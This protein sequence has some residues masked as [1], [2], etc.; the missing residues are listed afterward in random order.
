[1]TFNAALSCTCWNNFSTCTIGST[2]AGAISTSYASYSRRTWTDMAD[3]TESF[4]IGDNV[5]MYTFYWGP[6]YAPPH[7]LFTGSFRYVDEINYDIVT[8][9]C[10]CVSSVNGGITSLPI[11]LTSI[12]YTYPE[13]Y[14][15]CEVTVGAEVYMTVDTRGNYTTG[16]W[17]NMG[18]PNGWCSVTVKDY[19]YAPA[20]AQYY[21][22][23]LVCLTNAYASGDPGSNWNECWMQASETTYLEASP[24][25]VTYGAT[26]SNR[27]W[28]FYRQCTSSMMNYHIS[29][30]GSSSVYTLSRLRAGYDV[31][32][33]PDKYRTILPIPAFKS[34]YVCSNANLNC[35]CRNI[36]I[37][38]SVISR[39]SSG[40]RG[41]LRI[42]DTNKFLP[43]LVRSTTM[44][45]YP[46][47]NDVNTISEIETCLAR[48]RI[49]NVTR[50]PYNT[51]LTLCVPRYVEDD[52]TE[53]SGS[54][55]FYY[56]D[57]TTYGA[58][59]CRCSYPA[60]NAAGNTYI[61]NGEISNI[62]LNP[63]DSARA[64]FC[65]CNYG[66]VE[67]SRNEV[68]TFTYT[69]DKVETNGGFKGTCLVFDC[70]YPMGYNT[71][72]ISTAYTWGMGMAQ[73]G[74]MIT[75][76]SPI[77]TINWDSSMGFVKT[78]KTCDYITSTYVAR[79][80]TYS[81]SDTNYTGHKDSTGVVKLVEPRY[82]GTY[83]GYYI[84]FTASK[85]N[86]YRLDLTNGYI[87]KM[88]Y[89]SIP[90]NII[91]NPA[92]TSL[93]TRFTTSQLYNKYY[94]LFD[95]EKCENQS[96]TSEGKGFI[97]S[98]SGRNTCAI[99]SSFCCQRYLSRNKF[100]ERGYFSRT[101]TSNFTVCY[102]YY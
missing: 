91:G 14:V 37:N 70:K 56:D 75:Y 97:I 24:Q 49:T 94:T 55:F 98:T 76:T 72:I 36:H 6:P 31:V 41:S 90:I 27:G 102:L 13:I 89:S 30:C 43:Y 47:V 51:N 42:T 35:D 92:D 1:M 11:L 50:V 58:C 57:V 21:K 100:D 52:V 54:G 78:S 32:Y 26:I 10:C 38:N 5:S 66:R 85:T 44:V 99:M 63:N 9:S 23:D 17:V 68:F 18:P 81:R 60:I 53:S 59:I 64:T 25:G 61:A 2:Y 74:G 34:V 19:K 96:M 67:L 93:A 84:D 20:K 40:Y 4:T 46:L 77:G 88:K 22:R 86:G 83:T 28:C 39:V 8:K 48:V 33:M 79:T 101:N 87:K 12:G 29:T 16:G 65:I 69:R 15:G 45:T 95:W 73:N 62:I 80:T 7:C 3:H 71:S 82:A